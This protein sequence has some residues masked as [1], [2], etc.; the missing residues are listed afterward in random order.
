MTGAFA[1]GSPYGRKLAGLELGPVLAAGR[2]F[3]GEQPRTRAALR[4][5]LTARWPDRDAQSLSYAVH[6]LLPLVQVPP[7]GLWGKGGQPTCTT[8]E[9]WLGRPL[10]T[11]TNVEHVIPR[12]LAAFGP[13]TVA[14]PPRRPVRSTRVTSWPRMAAMRAA[15]NPAG[16]PPTTVTRRTRAAGASQ[17]GSSVSRPLVGSPMHVT[18]GLRASRTW[19]VWLQRVHGRMRSGVPARSL[20]TR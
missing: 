20:A 9:T 4:Q 11:K 3:L 16:P 8:A 2:A 14:R 6:Y 15:S 13:A 1:S 17:S 19:H 5:H 18:I 12:Y 10:S 7:R